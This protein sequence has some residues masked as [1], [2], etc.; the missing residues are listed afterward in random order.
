MFENLFFNIDENE[1]A[2]VAP[3]Q[4]TNPVATIDNGHWSADW[5]TLKTQSVTLEQLKATNREMMA[6]GQPMHGI[7][8]F[9]LVESVLQM[10]RER[11]LT[12][13]ITD[14]FAA[15]A[16]GTQYPGVSINEE[17]AN[18]LGNPLDVRAYTLRRVFSTIKIRETDTD[19]GGMTTAI[20]IAYTQKGI[21]V[22]CGRY[23]HICHNQTI[24]GREQSFATFSEHKGRGTDKYTFTDCLDR[25]ACWLN[26]IFQ[27]SDADD[28]MI[29]KMKQTPLTAQALLT[30]IGELTAIRVACDSAN[31]RIR[32]NRTYP[33][34]NTQINDLTEEM[35]VKFKDNGN[36]LSVW[37][38]YDTAT[39]M[40]K[41]NS[42]DFTQLLPQNIAMV[43]Y[44]NGHFGL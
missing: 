18:R 15:K 14:M 16:G 27:I 40:Y 2:V 22:A 5:N 23:I 30:I 8:H 39:N 34:N 35:L 17:V 32:L 10:A 12:P 37:D 28:A 21:Q 19:D 24:L 25:I 13:E 6:N 3:Q 41:A 4:V 26:N 33:L 44:L 42:M 29:R 7:Y 43:E 1:N 9:Q 36:V 11:G 20:A 31:K 38:L